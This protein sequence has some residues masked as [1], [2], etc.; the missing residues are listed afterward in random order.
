[1]KVCIENKSSAAITVKGRHTLRIPAE[2]KLETTMADTPQTSNTLNRL[3][4][5]Y[6]ALKITIDKAGEGS[7][8]GA[9]SGGQIVDPSSKT[10]PEGNSAPENEKAAA[11]ME[12]EAFIALAK[13][14]KGSG[15][16]WNVNVEGVKT[17]KVK[18]AADEA[19]AIELAYASYLESFSAPNAGQGEA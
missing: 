1:M 13:A 14:S 5:E 17:F 9:D 10:E 2:G 4:R 16:K 7:T 3:R 19:A 15:D 18:E 6:P 12:K 11:P 8:T